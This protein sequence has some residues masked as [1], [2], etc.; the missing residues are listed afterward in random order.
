MEKLNFT[1]ILGTNR[2]DRQSEHVYHYLTKVLQRRD[3]INLSLVDV[4]DFNLPQDEYGRD[5]QERFSDF[6]QTI[7]SSDALIIVTPEYNHSFPGRLKSVLDMLM[8]E[9]KRK[10]VGV[11]SVSAGMWGG[12]RAIENL[13]PILRLFGL[14]LIKKDLNFP[15][16]TKLFDDAGNLEQEKE[17]LY[18]G[19]VDE[20]MA[21]L[22][23]SARALKWGREN[24]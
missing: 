18:Q 16:V 10:P 23:W 1:L 20:F 6:S 13:A 19:L 14:W 21:E 12:V 24:L 4:K 17:E 22:E 11:A 3:S 7:Q 9:Y 2:K 15:N 8:S 5:I